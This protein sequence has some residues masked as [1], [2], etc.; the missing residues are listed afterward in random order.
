MTILK[1]RSVNPQHPPG[2][3]IALRNARRR[4]RQRFR[5]IPGTDSEVLEALSD[6]VAPEHLPPPIG[7]KKLDFSRWLAKRVREET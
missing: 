6:I 4:V 7:A 1:L 3:F 2:T 5:F